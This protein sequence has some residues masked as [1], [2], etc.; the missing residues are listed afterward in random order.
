[1]NVAQLLILRD[2]VTWRIDCR[3]TMLNCLGAKYIK[4]LLIHQPHIIVSI[5]GRV[6]VQPTYCKPSPNQLFISCGGVSMLSIQSIPIEQGVAAALLYSRGSWFESQPRYQNYTRI[7]EKAPK[8]Y[9]GVWIWHIV[10]R[11]NSFCLVCIYCRIITKIKNFGSQSQKVEAVYEIMFLI[12]FQQTA[13]V[14]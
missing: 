3:I 4:P 1:M 12:I 10:F 11:N 14:F 2:T 6:S 8:N 13:S 9:T 7:S 5:S